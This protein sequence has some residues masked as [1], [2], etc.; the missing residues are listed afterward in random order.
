M[1]ATDSLARLIWVLVILTGLSADCLP[2]WDSHFLLT[3]MATQALGHQVP[4]LTQEVAPTSLATFVK[5]NNAALKN[6]LRAFHDWKQKT[7]TYPHWKLSEANAALLQGSAIMTPV[8]FLEILGVS[9]TAFSKMVFQKEYV[10][11]YGPR[12]ANP[13]LPRSFG[14]W[15]TLFSDE[16]DW[17]MDQ[18]L[19]GTGDPRYGDIPYGDA[20]GTGSQ[21]PFHMTF[22]FE[23]W[24]T[25][26][27]KSS[28]KQGMAHLRFM[29][30]CS[31]TQVALN[32]GDHFWAARFLGSAVH[33][34]EDFT[35]PYHA[36]AVPFLNP[37]VFVK[38]IFAKDKERFNRE[39]TQLL[40]NRH[41]LYE[42]VAARAQVLAFETPES[43]LPNLQSRLDALADSL[44]DNNGKTA[45]TRLYARFFSL[46]KLAFGHAHKVDKLVGK[47]FP[48]SLVADPNYDPFANGSFDVT[49]Y[50]PDALVQSW[51]DGKSDKRTQMLDEARKDLSQAVE[52]AATAIIVILRP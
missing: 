14:E 2:A 16:P 31:L 19:F 20:A 13:H 41:K 1:K 4:L 34:F 27:L 44:A 7:Y 38:A 15:L 47:S 36:S 43:L 26:K 22:P 32:A 51:L 52:A 29:V 8:Q 30:F 33:Y 25:Y 17:G 42:A 46:G 5:R 35:M 9:S 23:N 18:G 24:V 37:L 39:N 40:S 12:Y 21:A 50:Y 45:N 49:P 3:R 28:L 48:K 11:L 10:D 6:T